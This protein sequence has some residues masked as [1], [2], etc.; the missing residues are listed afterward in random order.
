MVLEVAIAEG[1]WTTLVLRSPP[2]LEGQN[3]SPRLSSLPAGSVDR[4]PSHEI[5][6]K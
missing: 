2:P 5:G 4:H 6:A 3:P 1:N